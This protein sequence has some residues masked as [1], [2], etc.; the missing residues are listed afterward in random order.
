MEATVRRCSSKQVILKILQCSQENNRV[1]ISFKKGALKFFI[2][3]GLQHKYFPV[4]IAKILRAAF[5]IEH[6]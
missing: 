1:G 5:V 4:N 3:K 6:L 2:K